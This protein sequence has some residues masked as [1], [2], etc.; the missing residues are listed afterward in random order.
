MPA[1]LAI[2]LAVVGLSRALPERVSAFVRAFKR[3]PSLRNGSR[4]TASNAAALPS[5]AS[6]TGVRAL[7]GLRGDHIIRGDVL[8]VQQRTVPQKQLMTFRHHDAQS[9]SVERSPAAVY[10]RGTPESH[11]PAGEH[12]SACL[13]RGC[14]T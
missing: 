12:R 11:G 10:R 6:R 13:K 2:A 4:T 8:F 1:S 7:R 5:I 3:V 9:R 14:Q